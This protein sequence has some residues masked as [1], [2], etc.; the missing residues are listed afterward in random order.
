MLHCSAG[1]DS[2]PAKSISLD[3]NEMSNVTFVL[4]SYHAIG[5]INQCRCEL[6]SMHCII[7]VCTTNMS[8]I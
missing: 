1:I 5:K 2:V 6:E 7:T 8:E 4:H 3:P